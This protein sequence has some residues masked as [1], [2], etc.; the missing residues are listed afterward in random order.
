[1]I[2]QIRQFVISN[3]SIFEKKPFRIVEVMQLSSSGWRSF[4]TGRIIFIIFIG[5]KAKVV[6]KF[7]KSTKLN[8]FL[9]QEFNTLKSFQLLSSNLYSKPINLAKI[10]E[11]NV[12]FEELIE[13][14]SLL[15]QITKLDYIPNLSQK[16]LS[17][18][19]NKHFTITFN[20]FNLLNKSNKNTSEKER[21]QEV[22]NLISEYATVSFADKQLIRKINDFLVDNGFGEDFKRIVHFDIAPT[23][24]F[25]TNDS[26]K[27]I[28]LEF[29]NRSC[30]WY[31]EPA[32]YVS[33]YMGCFIDIG[34]IKN[35]L[36]EAMYSFR[37]NP[38]N[39][40]EKEAMK[41]CEKCF[42]NNDNLMRAAFILAFIK[43]YILQ[44]KV[45]AFI[46]SEEEKMFTDIIELWLKEK[47]LLTRGIS[48]RI[49]TKL[50]ET[51]ESQLRQLKEQRARLQHELS[52]I[53]SSRGWKMTKKMHIIRTKIPVLKNL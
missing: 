7:Y 9:V 17:D 27:L 50:E 1:M 33:H 3:W 5:G 6:A 53:T 39:I 19:V 29:S 47:N 28:D 44:K 20:I 10:N 26:Y 37:K 30:L 4:D 36:F 24:I 25:Q 42:N 22:E 51:V 11:H 23:N 35:T 32:I 40:F 31:I 41:F 2:E 21:I 14:D 45:R 43:S 13:G 49:S 16:Q 38:K 34:F 8:D 18:I 12:L 46:P 48:A 52:K 15:S